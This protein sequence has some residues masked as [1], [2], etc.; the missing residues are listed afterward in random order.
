MIAD[1]LWATG[2]LLFCA[3]AVTATLWIDVWLM[4]R[5]DDE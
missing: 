4:R 3:I 2:I 5:E 1:S